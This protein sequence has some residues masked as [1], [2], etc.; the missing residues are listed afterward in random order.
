MALLTSNT[1]ASEKKK[2]L[3]LL[4]SNKIQI[5][6]GTH[7]LFQDGVEFYD[8]ALVVIDEQHRFGVEQRKKLSCKGNKADVLLMSATPIPRTLSLT[9]YGDIALSTIS[10]K[11][12]N[13]LPIKTSVISINKIK[14]IIDK[15]KTNNTKV[16]WICPYIESS[17]IADVI[18]VEERFNL[19]Q[20]I[21]HK[22]VGLLHG[23]MPQKVK[24]KVMLD[25][26]SNNIQ[27]LVATTVIEVGIDI[28]DATV[29]IIENAEKFGLAQLH[30][31]RG[32]VGRGNQ[33]SFCI[34]LYHTV[35][36]NSKKRLQTMRDSSDGFFIAEE[37]LKLRG[38]G[39]LI[40]TKQ[41]GIPDFK[42]F[43]IWK[44]KNLLN[45]ACRQATEIISQDPS[46][47]LSNNQHYNI[48]LEIFKHNYKDNNL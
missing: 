25:F 4:M 44:H 26:K 36:D 6:I 3:E 29:I 16:Y 7:S 42:F 35:T 18:S 10:D 43:N 5:L 19:L 38:E 32:R 12:K 17:D 39:D 11:P 41:S 31:L 48:L 24:E 22:K 8:L 34:L 21:F 13:R 37:D 28:P 15:I 2:I 47:S 45:D 1:K 30:Q 46:L 40:G 20:G 23:K 33:Q 27:I 9:L 14:D